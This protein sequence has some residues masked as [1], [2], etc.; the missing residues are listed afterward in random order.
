MH[1]YLLHLL[2]NI[3]QQNQNFIF[4]FMREDIIKKQDIIFREQKMHTK[5][6]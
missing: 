1:G 2:K 5:M 4:G 3:N 6:Q